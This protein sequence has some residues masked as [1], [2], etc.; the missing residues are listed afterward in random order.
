[1]YH[2]SRRSG[3]VAAALVLTFCVLAPVEGRAQTGAV[4]MGYRFSLVR[5]DAEVGSSADRYSG[6]VLRARLYEMEVE[7]QQREQT[8]EDRDR[9]EDGGQQHGIHGG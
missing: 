3:S 6:G 4:G 7:K 2:P 1:M 8:E 9:G 5:G